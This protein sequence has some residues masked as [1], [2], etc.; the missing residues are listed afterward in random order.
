MQ[1]FLKLK[2]VVC[3]ITTVIESVNYLWSYY[4]STAMLYVEFE[5]KHKVPDLNSN[6][7]HQW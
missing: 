3:T 4:R 7:C 6:V 2:Q 1:I 5:L